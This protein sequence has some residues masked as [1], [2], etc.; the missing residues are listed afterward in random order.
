[1]CIGVGWNSSKHSDGVTE[2]EWKGQIQDRCIITGGLVITERLVQR[3]ALYT[4][5]H[6]DVH[7]RWLSSPNA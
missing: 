6:S 5:K 2:W 1:M 7:K 3:A 4:K